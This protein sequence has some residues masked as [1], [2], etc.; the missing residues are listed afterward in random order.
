MFF[1]DSGEKT[2]SKLDKDYLIIQ[3]YTRKIQMCKN[4]IRLT[5]GARVVVVGGKGRGGPT[6]R[7]WWVGGQ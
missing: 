6:A 1:N 7:R 5:E 2:L 3:K 4:L